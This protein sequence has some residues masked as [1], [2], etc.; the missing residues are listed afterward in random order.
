MNNNSK[1]VITVK[2]LGPVKEF[3]MEVNKFNLLIGEQASGKSTIAKCIYFFRTIKTYITYYLQSIYDSGKYAGKNVSEG[4]NKNLKSE[5]KSIFVSLFGYSWDLDDDLCLNYEFD[6]NKSVKVCL[7]KRNQNKMQKYIDIVFSKELQNEI[8]KL[9]RE[10]FDLYEKKN[11]LILASLG[12]IAQERTKLHSDIKDKVDT[13]FADT[14]ETYYI[15][16]GRSTITLLASNK[17]SINLENLD[18]VTRQFMKLIESVHVFFEKGISKAHNFFPTGGRAFDVSSLSDRIVKNLNGD[19]RWG[20]GGSE[21][22]VLENDQQIAINFIS[23]GQQEMLWLMN[24]LYVLMLKREKAFVI[25]EEP[26][27]HLYPSMQ[28]EIVSFIVNFT[29][30]NDS[31]VLITTHSPYVLTISNIFYCAGEILRNATKDDQLRKDVYRIIGNQRELMPSNF[32][33]FKLNRNESPQC[34]VNKD[35]GELSSELID[36]ISDKTT[37]MYMNLLKLS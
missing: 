12:Y 4:F 28:Q 30:I 31:S 29:N 27:A 3:E 1:Q 15:P 26:E 19:Y 32:S 22:L 8:T 33:A 37:E 34:M 2:N 10:I 24:L 11:P 13:I 35:F 20:N 17:A 9:E 36:D 14:L 18:L 5:W 21:F 7:A 16:A 6:V 23:S 25:I